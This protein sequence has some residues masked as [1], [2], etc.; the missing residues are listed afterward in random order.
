MIELKDTPSAAT[1]ESIVV[2]VARTF[3][4][5]DKVLSR[6]SIKTKVLLFILPFVISISAVGFTGLYATRL[7]Q[8]RMEISNSVL[9]SLTGFKNLYASM[10]DFLRSPNEAVRDKLV[11]EIE[12]QQVVLTATLGQIGPGS[13][14]HSDLTDATTKIKGVA[15]IVGKLWT[16]HQQE[17][18]LRAKMK[19]EQSTLIGARFNVSSVSQQLQDAMGESTTN[20]KA[21]LPILE[22]ARR[23]EGSIYSMQLVLGDFISATGK[24]NLIRLRQEIKKLG[25]DI[26]TFERSTRG[27]EIAGDI[28]MAIRPT[29]ASMELNGGKLVD[30]VEK[31]VGAYADA[32]QQLDQIWNQL[33]VFAQIQKESADAER[34]QAN[35]ISVLATSLGIVLS[36]VGGISLVLT[37]QRP[38]AQITAIMRRIAEGALDTNIAGEQ[39]FDE[40][41]DM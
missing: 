38:I 2:Q 24:E 36:I 3:T 14:G 8:S 9:Q 18:D 20:A 1:A 11:A 13:A 39:R 5:F 23:F 30:T 37:L 40:I 22:D 28:D 33:T 21:N 7:L 31:K 25:T 6:Y 4:S 35:S 27:S 32:H 41:G 19:A 16:L 15:V 10:D 29:I 17:V 34:Q 12:S 26:G